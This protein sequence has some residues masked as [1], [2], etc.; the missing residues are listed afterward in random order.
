MRISLKTDDERQKS[1]PAEVVNLADRPRALTKDYDK[2][3]DHWRKSS[4][5]LPKSTPGF[6][7]ASGAQPDLA[8]LKR[9]R[10]RVSDPFDE[11]NEFG[12]ENPDDFDDLPSLSQLSKEHLEVVTPIPT[13]ISK[14]TV[15]DFDH[16]VKGLKAGV[17]S[18]PESIQAIETFTDEAALCTSESFEND[19]FDFNAFDNDDYEYLVKEASLSQISPSDKSQPHLEQKDENTRSLGKRQAA[20]NVDENPAVKYRRV[21]RETQNESS[22]IMAHT[23]T[24]VLMQDQEDA[25][26]T[27]PEDGEYIT[28]TYGGN[29]V[30]VRKKDGNK[31]GLPEWV[32]TDVPPDV[33]EEYGDFVDF[34]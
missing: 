32:M 24:D 28:L 11:E 1:T 18:L 15:E 12:S 16:S 2:A 10:G 5:R 3:E 7:Y 27:Q 14:L 23:E 20:A 9:E 33:Y 22:R 30:T 6:S 25:P 26:V 21:T 4:A 29:N 8:F 13:P 17:I 19:C 31:D 34:V